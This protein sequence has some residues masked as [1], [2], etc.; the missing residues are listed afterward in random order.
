MA[1][2]RGGDVAEGMK[3]HRLSIG[4]KPVRYFACP[5]TDSRAKV[6]P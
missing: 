3:R 1:C 2:A 4:P 5:V 6:R